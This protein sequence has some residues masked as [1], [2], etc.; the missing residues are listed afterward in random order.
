MR[1]QVLEHGHRPL[2]KMILRLFRMILR[3]PVPGPVLLLS[4][5]RELL[6]KYLAPCFHEALRGA[7]EWTVSEVELFAAFVSRLNECRY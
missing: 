3:G 6:G 2:Q 5:R 4:Y 7:T 1:L